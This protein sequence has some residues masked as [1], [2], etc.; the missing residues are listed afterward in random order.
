MSDFLS[1]DKDFGM[2]PAKQEELNAMVMKD[3]ET[4][5]P[6][7]LLNCTFM[8]SYRDWIDGSAPAVTDPG[9]LFIAS[10][11]NEKYQK[12]SM[13]GAM[14]RD[15]FVSQFG[16]AVPTPAFIKLFKALPPVVEVG[17]GRGYLSQLLRNNGIDAIATDRDP[18]YMNEHTSDILE[19]NED[20]LNGQ[21]KAPV[22]TFEG[23]IAVA[24][25]PD[26]TVLCSWPGLGSE[27]LFDTALQMNKDQRMI[28]IGEGGGAT[29]DD[30]L[31]DLVASGELMQERTTELNQIAEN[32]I[33]SFP[34]I[35]DRIRI[36]LR[37]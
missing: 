9:A 19:L 14:I 18:G 27:W 11:V 37:K 16:Y 36:F 28:V 24:H 33:W 21:L 29:G 25:H 15:L 32:A 26:R 31:F 4:A 13:T 23:S 35:N 17:A 12:M 3:I 10:G 30:C 5:N 7:A 8:N 34:M 1:F 22:E 20:F 6:A 2:S